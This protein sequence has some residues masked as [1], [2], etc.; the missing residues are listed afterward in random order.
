MY[1]LVMEIVEDEN[2]LW[3]NWWIPKDS[4][5]NQTSMEGTLQLYRLFSKTFMSATSSSLKRSCVCF[6]SA[7]SQ[8]WELVGFSWWT[9]CSQTERHHKGLLWRQTQSPQRQSMTWGNSHWLRGWRCRPP[10]LYSHS[11]SLCLIW[12]SPSLLPAYF[13]F[14]LMWFYNRSMLFAFIFWVSAC[15]CEALHAVK[16][17]SNISGCHHVFNPLGLYS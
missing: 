6:K 14:R 13:C 10:E 4:M 2:G 3:L 1:M 11:Y 8:L 5:T 16:A 17:M 7:E 9:R 12:N 15:P